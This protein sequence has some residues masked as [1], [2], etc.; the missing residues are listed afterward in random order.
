MTIVG[1]G[2]AGGVMAIALARSGI[3]NFNL[4]DFDVYSLSNLNRQIGCFMDT[5]GKYKS[6]VVKSEILRINPEAKV[7]AITRKVTFNE[8]AELLDQ[9]DVYA[10][11]ADD[12]AYSSYAMRL[13]QQKNVFSITFM[14]SGL[15]GYILAIPP[16]LP[17]S[18]IIITILPPSPSSPWQVTQAMRCIKN[19]PPVRVIDLPEALSAVKYI[20][21]PFKA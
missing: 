13:A 18:H 15:T 20:L 16:D 14:P 11:E 5:L 17:I 9:S 10:S 2:G 7:N 21:S 4:V 3:A 1:V 12:L 6:E 8:L 19:K